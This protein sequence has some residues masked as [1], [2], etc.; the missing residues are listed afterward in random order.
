M[1]ATQIKSFI[2]HISAASELGIPIIVHSRN[3]E[4]D[5]YE[6]LKRESKNFP[7]ASLKK[8]S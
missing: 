6:I 8:K 7:K 1:I 5:T 4:T 2:D 3:A